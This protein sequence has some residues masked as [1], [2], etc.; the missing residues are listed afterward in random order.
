M[1]SPHRQYT[2]ELYDKFDYIA[3][4]LPTAPIKLG[5]V[6]IVAKS[7]FDQLTSLE[8]LDISFDVREGASIGQ[9][10][11]ATEG[12]VSVHF[13][14]Q[15]EVPP[16]LSQLM[17][18]EAGVIIEMGRASATLFQAA[19]A[20]SR[21]IDDPASLGR[22]ILDRYK[23]GEWDGHHFVV[24]EVMEAKAATILISSSA[25]ARVEF[26]V[27]GKATVG[28]LNLTDLDAGLRIEHKRN[29]HT[30]IVAR[31]GLVPLFRARRVHRRYL[32]LGEAIFREPEPQIEFDA[33]TPE[34]LSYED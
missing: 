26:S 19:D 13:K 17:Q 27:S 31:G 21:S 5:D 4:W 1:P 7:G 29:L 15:G 23:L 20:R 9:F 2:K 24:T 16:P 6:G 34:H 14:A 28:V 33:I 25:D 30:E 22:R 32:G 8:K 10:S 3:T 12:A 18:A 11:Y